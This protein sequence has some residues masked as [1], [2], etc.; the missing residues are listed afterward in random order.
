MLVLAIIAWS[1]GSWL[2]FVWLGVRTRA[3]LWFVVAGVS[4]ASVALAYYVSAGTG[5]DSTSAT[6]GSLVAAANWIWRW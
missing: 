6:V 1:F 5:T 3:R 2:V 4:A